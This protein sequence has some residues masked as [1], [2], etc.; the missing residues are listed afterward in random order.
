MDSY[1]ILART[2]QVLH[3]VLFYYFYMCPRG[4]FRHEG[5]RVDLFSLSIIVGIVYCLS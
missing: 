5:G 2:T 3:I 4:L 1:H